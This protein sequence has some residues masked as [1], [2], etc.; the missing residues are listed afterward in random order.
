MISRGF[1]DPVRWEASDLSSWPILASSLKAITPIE[2]ES[3]T[4]NASNSLLPRE[5]NKPNFESGC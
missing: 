4:G 1:T 5:V 2:H 3:V